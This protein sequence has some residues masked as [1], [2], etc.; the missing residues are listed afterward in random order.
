MT[1][2]EDASVVDFAWEARSP[3]REPVTHG[4]PS[5]GAAAAGAGGI[6]LVERTGLE[7]IQLMARRGR[8]PATVEVARQHFGVEPPE[9]PAAVSGQGL[10]EIQGRGEVTGQGAG[11][12]TGQGTGWTLIWSAPGQFLALSAGP[13]DGAA[14]RAARPA[15][16][17]AASLSDQS[18]GR[19]MVEVIGTRARDVL[20]R[21]TVVDLDPAL[22]PPGAAAA[23]SIDHTTVNL[24]RKPD[25]ADGTPVYAILMLTSF[26]ASIWHSLHEA[27]EEFGVSTERAAL[28]EVVAAR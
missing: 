16:Q 7:L 5:S 22:F 13:G 26:A 3:L 24:W 23:T 14:I 17:D 12:G 18:D 25:L 6:R 10:G 2:T 20:S 8:W 4:H 15:F 21:L 19:F 11:Q 28:D 27:A 9:R 1:L